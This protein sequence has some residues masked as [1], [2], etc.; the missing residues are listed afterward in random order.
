MLARMKQLCGVILIAM[1]VAC[2]GKEAAT[3]PVEGDC[4]AA[5]E[6]MIGLAMADI[7]KNAAQ[8][9]AMGAE[10]ADLI[11]KI[12]ADAEKSRESDLAT[13]QKQCMEGKLNTACAKGTKTIDEIAACTNRSG[14]LH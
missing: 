2:G 14:G 12:K 13:C 9:A 6:H 11:A 1:L 8:I 4:R 5:C 3:K 7:D 10:G